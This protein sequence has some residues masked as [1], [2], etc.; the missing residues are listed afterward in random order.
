[1]IL[2]SLIVIVS[3]FFWGGG[4]GWGGGGGVEI[5]EMLKVIKIFI[6]RTCI[7]MKQR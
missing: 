3:I 2:V 7:Y 1:M 6:E 5:Q 4:E